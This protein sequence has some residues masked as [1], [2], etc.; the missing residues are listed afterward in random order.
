M[1]FLRPH[2]GRNAMRSLIWG[3]PKAELHIHIE[4]TL[5]PS[6]MFKLARRNAV[7]LRFASVEEVER[8]YQFTNLQ[9][10]LDIYYEGCRVL[11]HERDFYDLAMDYFRRIAKQNVRHVELF[12]DPQSHSDRGVSFA[13]VV[14]GM[15][16]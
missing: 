10:F 4:G 1:K 15:H 7:A 8:A 2:M 16:L 5:R 14:T 12:F 3:T 13:T 11:I 9:S 6:L